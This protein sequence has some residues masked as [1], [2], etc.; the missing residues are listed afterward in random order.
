MRRTQRQSKPFHHRNQM[1]SRTNAFSMASM[2]VTDDQP[3]QNH[4]K[5]IKKAL[6][7]SHK[8][9]DPSGTRVKPVL[10]EKKTTRNEEFF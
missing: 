9:F 2:R 1:F 7:S 10:F 5:D 6:S 8:N 4:I 3:N